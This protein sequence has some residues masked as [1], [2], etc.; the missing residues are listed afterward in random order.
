MQP[1]PAQ[2]RVLPSHAGRHGTGGQAGRESTGSRRFVL[3]GPGCCSIRGP[4]SLGLGRRLRRPPARRNLARVRTRLWPA[5]IPEKTPTC[6]RSVSS[7]ASAGSRLTCATC[8]NPPSPDQIMVV[9]VHGNRVSTADVAPRRPTG[10]SP[11]D[12]GSSAT[13]PRCGLSFGPG[14]AHRF[15]DNCATCGRRPN[16]RNCPDTAWPG[17]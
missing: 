13:R 1:R 17:C 9:F 6:A 2:T 10:V 3:A 5:S 14:P 7:P 11:A 4:G 16:A 8:I 12:G 15:V